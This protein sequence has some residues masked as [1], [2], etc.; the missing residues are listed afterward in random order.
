MHHYWNKVL[1]S[2]VCV[3]C[4]LAVSFVPVETLWT[5][6]LYGVF[7]SII[8]LYLPGYRISFMLFSDNELSAFERFI[9]SGAISLAC[10]TFFAIYVDYFSAPLTSMSAIVG[11]LALMFLTRLR[12]V[13]VQKRG[14]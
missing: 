6:I 5:Q 3:M 2:Q 10:M 13:S 11:A 14:S 7:A 4:L 12:L 9:M 8:V 1:W